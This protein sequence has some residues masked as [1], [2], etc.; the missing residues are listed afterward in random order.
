MAR[1]YAK[2]QTKRSSKRSKK[3]QKKQGK[4]WLLLLSLVVLFGLAL[5]YLSHIKPKTSTTTVTVP[6]EKIVTTKI[7]PPQKPVA[8]SENKPQDTEPK[9]DFYTILP[10]EQVKISS[11]KTTNNSERFILQ[12]SSTKKYADADQLK[13]ELALLGFE[14]YIEEVNSSLYRVNIG[15]YF[16]SQAAETDQKRL[17]Q[18]NIKSAILKLKTKN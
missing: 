14:A 16:S 5:L 11:P 15:P 4:L 1:D 9:Y 6:Q 8:K 7:S 18:S 10:H 3:P 17:A 12:I 13:A 2:M